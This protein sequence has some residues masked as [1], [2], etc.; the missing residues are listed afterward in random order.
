M[1]KIDE[2]KAQMST[3]VDEAYESGAAAKAAECEQILDSERKAYYEKGK[4]DGIKEARETNPTNPAVSPSTPDTES[5]SQPSLA[6]E[7]PITNEAVKRFMADPAYNAPGFATGSGLSVVDNY[8]QSAVEGDIQSP[9]EQP[10][11]IPF[12]YDDILDQNGNEVPAAEG[13]RNLIPGQTYIFIRSQGNSHT[14]GTFRTSGTVRMIRT[15][16][17]FPVLNIRDLGGYPCEGG[18]VAYGRLIRAGHLPKELSKSDTTTQILRNLGISAEISFSSS[19]PARSDLGWKAYNYSLASYAAILTK[20][21]YLKTSLS[22]I[23]TEAQAGGCTLVHCQAGADRT[24]TFAA[25][26]LALLG[27]S[28]ADIIKD[29]ELT[30]FSASFN[31]K[32]ISDWEARTADPDLRVITL[33]EAPNGELR[34]LFQKLQ[35]A[36]GTKGQSLQQ[37]VTAF[38]TTKVGLSSE[39]ITAIKDAFIVP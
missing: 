22:R 39:M 10:V 32:R 14:R 33:Q 7:Y 37:Q 28:E 12:D 30:S 25:I 24:G 34:Q 18:H 16:D 23:L 4:A 36:Y 31:R 26:V 35:S 2:I 15:S 5:P 6:D 27:V 20:T 13:I 8:I 38:L 21:S 17:I 9:T 29:W 19:W 1:K 3:L 11:P